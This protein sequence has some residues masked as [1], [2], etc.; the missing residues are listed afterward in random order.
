[1]GDAL[2][3]VD[4]LVVGEGVLL[5]LQGDGILGELL[6]LPLVLEE[7]ARLGGDRDDV[8]ADKDGGDPA[9]L[10][11]DHVDGPDE[12]G[13][14]VNSDQA[15][16]RVEHHFLRGNVFPLHADLTEGHAR[17]DQEEYVA[18]EEHEPLCPDGQASPVWL[19]QVGLDV[20][21]IQQVESHPEE[22]T[23]QVLLLP[24]GPYVLHAVQGHQHQVKPRHAD[25]EEQGQ[26]FP[27]HRLQVLLVCFVI[28][29]DEVQL[30][31]QHEDVEEPQDHGVAPLG[32]LHL[33]PHPH[34]HVAQHDEEADV[35]H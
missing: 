15:E 20:Q 18:V 6:H 33:R 1:M 25:G 2:H 4:G 22:A 28:L 10:E 7:G 3:A 12:D 29:K 16:D 17:Q 5:E 30:D 19:P 9:V 23:P 27:G 21:D 24:K 26:G 8:L 32:R 14:D 11:Q 31:L 35:P 34:R 13:D